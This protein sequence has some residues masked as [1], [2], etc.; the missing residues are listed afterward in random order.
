MVIADHNQKA[1]LCVLMSLDECY[2]L[3]VQPVLNANVY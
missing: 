2:R 3:C 1:Y